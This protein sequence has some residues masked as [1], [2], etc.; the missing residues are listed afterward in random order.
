MI[1]STYLSKFIIHALV[2]ILLSVA[3]TGYKNHVFFVV[4][5][6]IFNACTM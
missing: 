2:T 1:A 3:D 6:S 5:L 4:T